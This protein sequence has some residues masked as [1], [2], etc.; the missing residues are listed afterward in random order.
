MGN[1]TEAVRP[2]SAGGLRFWGIVKVENFLT[3]LFRRLTL[4]RRNVFD[5]CSAQYASQRVPTYLLRLLLYVFM[6]VLMPPCIYKKNINT[7]KTC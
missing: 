3:T 5:C 6:C 7:R 2:G 4:R 1:G